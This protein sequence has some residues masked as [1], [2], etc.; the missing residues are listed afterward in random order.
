MKNLDIKYIQKNLRTLEFGR[1]LFY[2]DRL[3]S[4]SSHL[5][6][7]SKGLAGQGTVV[8]AEQ[9]T[10]GRGRQGNSWYSPPGPGLYFSLL[11]KPKLPSIKLSGLTLALGCSAAEAIEKVVKNPIAVKWPNDLYCNSRK[12]GG[13]LTEMQSHGGLIDNAV[14]GIGLNV[15][16]QSVP[17]ELS[18]IASSLLLETGK[19]CSRED[20]LIGLLTRL[21][22]D[23][24]AFAKQGLPAFADRLSGRF[25]LKG[26][27]ASVQ[28][29]LNLQLKGVVIGFD[30]DGGLL[31][32]DDRGRT[33][34]CSSGT[35]MEMEP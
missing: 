29:G 31:L 5:A 8:I 27:R 13:I 22:D 14:V 3:D 15:N 18:D 30:S 23:Y 10:A 21:E 9:Q 2:F 33:V 20:L 32:A 12:V 35:V 6:E 25:F 4:T 19:T 16:N 7:L 28:D 34:K 1:K 17:P 11:L 26:K 24:R